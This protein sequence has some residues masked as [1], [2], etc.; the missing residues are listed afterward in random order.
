MTSPDV[1]VVG[2]GPAGASTAHALARMGTRVLL[3]DRARFPRP[4]P[5]AECLSPQASR[6]LDA[7]GVL[8]EV[9]RAGPAQLSGILVRAPSGATIRGSYA[10]AH[11]FT[12]FRPCG[13][14]IPRETLDAILLESARRAGAD[15]REGVHVVDLARDANGRVAGVVTLDADGQRREIRARIVV[16]ADGLQSVVA[17]RLGLAHRAR[18]P[19]RIALTTRVRGLAG[20]GREVELHVGRTGFVGL[21]D[22]GDGLT[23]VSAVFPARMARE[24]ARDPTAFLFDW[25]AAQAPLALR[26][27]HATRVSPVRA[28][29]PFASRARRAWAPGALLVGDA[30]DFFDPFTGEGIYCALRGGELAALYARASLDATTPRETD[31]ALAAYDRARRH[32]FRGKWLVEQAIG[33]VIARPPLIN[34]AA[35]VLE[36]RRDM[37]DLLAGVTGD[38]VP[39][40]RVL[41]PSFLL[42]LFVLPVPHQ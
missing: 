10:G 20:V 16:G 9:E 8:D 30:A 40:S 27:A 1:I 13:L 35:R 25:L 41:R 15:V 4:K 14:S 24:I 36:A 17:A 32:E 3:L 26:F 33:A 31:A 19:R 12:P 28:V 2:G 5:C 22:V 23:N 7:M 11:G 38:F 29:G 42:S 37:A 39:A 18:W 21:A 34:R 6:I